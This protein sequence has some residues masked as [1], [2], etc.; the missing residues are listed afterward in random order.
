M[1]N[2]QKVSLHRRI[3]KVSFEIGKQRFCVCVCVRV[4]VYRDTHILIGNES[5][6][7]KE[8]SVS[9]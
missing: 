5:D 4:C 6:S 9:Y 3:F 8:V 2:F 7:T 1:D